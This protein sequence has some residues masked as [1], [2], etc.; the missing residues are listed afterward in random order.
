MR[1]TLYIFL[2]LIFASCK[3]SEKIPE[4][5]QNS[6]PEKSEM[7]PRED[8][9]LTLQGK[10][11]DKREEGIS[12]YAFGE[13]PFWEMT[14]DD[15]DGLMFSSQSEFGDLNAIEVE[16]MQPQD[17]N[18]MVY[19]AKTDDGTISAMVFTDSCITD[20][21]EKLPF[22][23]SISGKKGKGSLAEFKGCGLYLNNPALHDIWAV[24]GW[25]AL[26]ANKHI[27]SGSYLEFNMKTQRIYGNLGCG[28]IEG[29]FTPMGDK[30]KIYGLDYRNKPCE[31]NGSGKELFDHLNFNTHK[32]VIDGLDLMLISEQ[33]TVLFIKAD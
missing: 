22:R 12:F 6:E 31:I 10:Y 14:I 4:S 5:S 2:L 19:G 18:A 27:E 29:S 23:L 21:G 3:Q 20:K 11:A 16:G 25:S 1:N 32:L 33:D 28:E 30:I 26:S 15:Q 8:H 17:L 13:N 24:K 9:W 7:N